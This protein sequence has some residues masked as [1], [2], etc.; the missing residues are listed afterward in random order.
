MN[1]ANLVTPNLIN[2]CSQFKIIT[3]LGYTKTGKITIAKK[4]ADELNYPLFISDHYINVKNRQQS[5]YDL[6][7][8]ILP[9]YQSNKPLIVEGVLCFRLLRK[10]LQLKNF[11]T[12]VIIKTKCN[13][14]TI[15]YFYE[16]D[17]EP[18]KI[19]RALSFNKGLNT[20]WN[21]Y[22]LLLKSR[23]E[24]KRPKYIELD[25]TLPQLRNK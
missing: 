5:L 17:N 6:M 7:D 14:S 1:P 4:L 16:K 18:D 8:H 15:K 25:T 22:L 13:D 3:I 2:Y 19:S 20:I 21:E 12:D 10:G 9:Y 11:H 24:L 23:P